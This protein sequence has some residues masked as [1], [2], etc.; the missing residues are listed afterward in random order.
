MSSCVRHGQRAGREGRA[1]AWTGH[2]AQS[3]PAGE[4][5]LREVYPGRVSVRVL[6]RASQL[7]GVISACVPAVT[8]GRTDRG[9]GTGPHDYEGP[10]HLASALSR[11]LPKSPPLKMQVRVAGQIKE[12]QGGG[13]ELER[14]ERTGGGKNKTK[15]SKKSTKMGEEGTAEE[16]K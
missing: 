4:Q 2:R 7:S 8:G 10:G 15:K 14:H 6:A 3:T 12:G 16:K 11:Y 13:D 5:R 9:G 1:S